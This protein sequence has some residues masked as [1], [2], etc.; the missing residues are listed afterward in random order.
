MFVFVRLDNENAG[1][2]GFDDKMSLLNV[3]LMSKSHDKLRFSGLVYRLNCGLSK[4]N[5]FIKNKKEEYTMALVKFSNANG[6]RRTP[7]TTRWADDI[8]APFFSDSFMGDRFISRV[9]AVNIAETQ[10]A[11][12]VELAAPGLSKEDFKINVDNDVITV[13]AEKKAESENAEK[14]YN[15]REYSYTSFTR[16]FTLPDTADQSKIDARYKDGVLQ[17]SVGKREEAKVVSRPIEV[18]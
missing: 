5:T 14:H 16:S 6:T 3:F 4:V 7:A 1:K 12:E 2:Y 13:S 8:F 18:K 10:E 9:P 11:Y 17:L 15:K